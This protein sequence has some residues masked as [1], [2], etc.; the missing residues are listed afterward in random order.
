MFA[1]QGF[2]P[3]Q[4]GAV[5]FGFIV[6][7]IAVAADLMLYKQHRSARQNLHYSFFGIEDYFNDSSN[8]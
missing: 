8:R 3:D 1:G 5:A 7:A 2:S 6:S 4:Q